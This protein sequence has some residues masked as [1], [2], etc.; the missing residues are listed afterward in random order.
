MDYASRVNEYAERV[1]AGDIPACKLTVA[2]CER[3]LNDLDRSAEGKLDYWFSEDEA[4]RICG[5]V[6]RFPH[7]KGHWAR[8]RE[9]I[10]LEDWQCFVLGASHGWLDPQGYRRFRTVYIEVPRKNAKTTLSAPVALDKLTADG[11]QGAEVTIAATKK[12]QARIAFSIAHSMVRK[13]EAFRTE[14]SVLVRAHEIMSLETDSVMKAIDARGSTQDGANLHFSLNDELHAWKGR[15][16]YAV[17]ETAMGSRLQP[18]MWNITTAG[19]DQSGICYEKRQY[20]EKVLQGVIADEQLFGVIYSIDEGDDIYAEQT[21]R[22]AN[23]NYGVSVLPQDMRALALQAKQNPKSRADFRMKRLN[24]WINAASQYF[25]LDAWAHC[26]DTEM[27]ALALQA[28]QNPKSRADFRMKR[29]NVWINAASQYFDLDAWAHCADTEMRAQDFAG[30]PCI[31]ALDLASKRDC[32]AAIRLFRDDDGY[33]LFTRFWLP[34]EAVQQGA[35]ASYRGWVEE[36]WLETT[37]G[38]VVDYD[39]I[40]DAVVEGWAREHEISL[41]YDPFQAQALINRFMALDIPCLEMRPTVLNFSEPMKEFDALIASRKIRHDGN[42]VMSWMMSN[43]VA[44]RDRKDNVYPRKER[45]ENK[46]DGPVAAIMALAVA[47]QNSGDGRSVYED[48][49]LLEVNL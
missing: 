11:E 8:G 42:P 29:L 18:M 19:A 34:E 1:A 41:V 45:D 44:V 32:N 21:W 33:A 43:V 5:F 15:D 35:N 13:S 49:G 24:V 10:R 3:Q 39:A 25:D 22:K 14:F 27:R 2:A 31:V 46:I 36:G 26:A 23:P 9:M 20:L 4:N 37:P 7:V 6:E 38:N 16:L 48:R 47:L 28:R 17:L 12:D 40:E 30:E